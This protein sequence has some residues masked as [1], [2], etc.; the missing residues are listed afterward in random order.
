MDYG[1]LSRQR[2]KT[3]HI[4]H[5]LFEIGL[6]KFIKHRPEYGYNWQRVNTRPF[7]WQ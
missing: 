3:K 7:Q 1:L 2:Q 5:V 4:D 6:R